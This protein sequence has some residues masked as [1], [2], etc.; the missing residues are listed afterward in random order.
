MPVQFR[1]PDTNSWEEG[2]LRNLSRS[3]LRI[4]TILTTTERAVLSAH[5][6]VDIQLPRL[7][8]EGRGVQVQC[9]GKVVRTTHPGDPAHQ[10]GFGVEVAAYGV[11]M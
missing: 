5:P 3:G 1:L 11:D 6:S 8:R 9:R 10:Q 2:V 4:D 7:R